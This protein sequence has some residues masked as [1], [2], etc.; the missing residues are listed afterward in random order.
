MMV[1]PVYRSV[2][3]IALTN[4][5]QARSLALP[6]LSLIFLLH[7]STIDFLDQVTKRNMKNRAFNPNAFTP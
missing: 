7:I 3:E 2:R 4:D 6:Q 1:Y 5:G